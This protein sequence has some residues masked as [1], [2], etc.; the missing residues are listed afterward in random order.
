MSVNQGL[1]VATVAAATSFAPHPHTHQPSPPP[2]LVRIMKHEARL[3]YRLI[4]YSEVAFRRLARA[5]SR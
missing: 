1:D 5:K 3:H 4:T 2:Q